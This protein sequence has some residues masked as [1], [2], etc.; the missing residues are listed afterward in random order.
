MY[1]KSGIDW[2]KNWFMQFPELFEFFPAWFIVSIALTLLEVVLNMR[3]NSSDSA[4]FSSLLPTENL[5][6]AEE[7]RALKAVQNESR[8]VLIESIQ[9][10]KTIYSLTP[11]GI[12][13][14][15]VRKSFEELSE[16]T[17]NTL[18][19]VHKSFMVAP[20]IIERIERDGRNYSLI[21]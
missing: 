7:Q 14:E 12:S 4:E 2:W 15:T 10:Y 21:L 1:E 5:V 18:L 6:H 3:V 17:E 8:I 20:D 9:Q 16:Y 19:Q 11:E 13:E